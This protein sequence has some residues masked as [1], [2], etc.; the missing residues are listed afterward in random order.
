MNATHTDKPKQ[1][2]SPK[3]ALTKD[4]VM[5]ELG[6]SHGTFWSYVRKYPAEFRT[7]KSGRNR[8]MDPEDLAAWKEFCKVRDA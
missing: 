3:T 8:V 1:T 7:Y 4:E 2:N 5:H 6:I